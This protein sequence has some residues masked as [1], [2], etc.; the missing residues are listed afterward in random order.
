MKALS[1]LALAPVIIWSASVSSVSAGICYTNGS[2]YYS[3]SR[4]DRAYY[5]PHYS[6][7]SSY[8]FD[9]R[10]F[11]GRDEPVLSDDTIT[12]AMQRALEAFA[13]ND[14]EKAES[15]VEDLKGLAPYEGATLL[16]QA[17][18]NMA[19]EDYWPASRQLREIFRD[20]PESL[21]EL[22]PAD[23]DLSAITTS[24]REFY[25]NEVAAAGRKA[26][27]AAFTLAALDYLSGDFSSAADNLAK[28]RELKNRHKKE[29]SN[30]NLLISSAE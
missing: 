11:D 12:A 16:G 26:D 29:R 22:N 5:R 30:L 28:A 8:Y 7:P 20:E 27:M 4:Y 19:E 6:Y 23:Y 15:I 14:L 18:F 10:L 9:H 17:L 3:G 1:L 24:A 25:E 2:Y 13:E 21:K